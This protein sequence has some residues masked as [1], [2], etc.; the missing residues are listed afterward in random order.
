MDDVHS[1]V[2]CSIRLLTS[3]NGVWFVSAEWMRGGDQTNEILESDGRNTAMEV[4]TEVPFEMMAWCYG[5]LQ[6]EGSRALRLV[7]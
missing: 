5:S 3:G 2:K 4:G 6:K 1:D 7:P